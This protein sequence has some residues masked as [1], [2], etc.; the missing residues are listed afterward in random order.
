MLDFL[1]R[2]S[3]SNRIVNT[4]SSRC[5][6]VII[7]YSFHWSPRIREC[8][9][10]CC[11]WRTL[12]PAGVHVK[13]CTS[14]ELASFRQVRRDIHVDGM[15]LPPLQVD[16]LSHDRATQAPLSSLMFP[17]AKVWLINSAQISMSQRYIRWCIASARCDPSSSHKH[18]QHRKI[19]NESVSGIGWRCLDRLFDWN[20]R[21]RPP[22]MFA[23]FICIGRVVPLS[24][25]NNN[26]STL[27]VLAPYL[28]KVVVDTCFIDDSE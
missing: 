10:W 17:S 24:R 14:T 21:L 2:K 19:L 3:E 12:S 20:L 22:W 15:R 11:L 16:V 13:L 23:P 8:N 4:P 9:K 26:E 7:Q 28:Y 25:C 18:R 27:V 1:T 6:R 5:S